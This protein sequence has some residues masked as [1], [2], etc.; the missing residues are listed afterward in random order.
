MNEKR[1]DLA[2]FGN[3]RAFIETFC[4]GFFLFATGVCVHLELVDNIVRISKASL[5]VLEAIRYA[6][7]LCA[8]KTNAAKKRRKKKK[9][10]NA[11]VH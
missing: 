7:S 10:I 8:R 6:R 4:S 3:W 1:R 9:S 11:P 2:I 5:F